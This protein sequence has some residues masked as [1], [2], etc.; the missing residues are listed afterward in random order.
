MGINTL[1]PTL[2]ADGTIHALDRGEDI[3]AAL[4]GKRIAIDFSTLAYEAT[5]QPGRNHSFQNNQGNV[6]SL[7]L[8]RVSPL[9]PFTAPTAIAAVASLN[10]MPPSPPCSCLI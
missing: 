10:G 6:I 9:C 8:S 3:A 4:N 7:T 1:W 5:T 2:K